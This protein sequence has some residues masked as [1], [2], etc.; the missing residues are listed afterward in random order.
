VGMWRSCGRLLTHTADLPMVKPGDC[1]PFCDKTYD[2]EA[3]AARL[4]VESCLLTQGSKKHSLA[5]AAIR[6]DHCNPGAHSPNI[7]YLQM[8][9]GP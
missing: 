7:A 4:P 9:E 8:E 5:P 6:H 3:A 1:V 2:T